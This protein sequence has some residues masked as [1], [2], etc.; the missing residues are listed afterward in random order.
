MCEIK[1]D[2][3]FVHVPDLY[4]FRYPSL[5][6]QEVRKQRVAQEAKQKA[7]DPQATILRGGQIQ[8]PSV[9]LAIQIVFNSVSHFILVCIV[10]LL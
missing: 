7:K 5:F 10:F 1:V 2:G 9:S 4:K 3:R 8:N 6:E